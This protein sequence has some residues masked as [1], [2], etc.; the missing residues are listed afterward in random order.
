MKLPSRKPT[1][2]DSEDEQK[3]NHTD[4]P[5][6]GGRCCACPK[7]DNQL[8]KELEEIEYRKT[9]ENYLHN[10]VFES[11][12]AR[13]RPGVSDLELVGKGNQIGAAAGTLTA[14]R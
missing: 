3:W 9:F 6:S 11:R 5:S 14:T 13:L 1:H 10:E 8:K 2:L 7:T 4:E 12:Y